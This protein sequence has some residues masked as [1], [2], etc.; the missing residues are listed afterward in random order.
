MKK[1]YSTFC[2]ALLTTFAIAQTDT[3]AP[4]KP[5]KHSGLYSLG[6]TQT[7]LSNWAAG[8]SNSSNFAVLLKQAATLNKGNNT[9]FNLLEVNFGYSIQPNQDVKTDDKIEFTTRYD[10]E[11]G[12]PKWSVSAFGNVRTQL[13]D[14]FANP[15]DS[16]FPDSLRISSFLSPAYATYGL[17][18]TNK[19]IDGLVVYISPATV[20]N[21]FVNDSA[22]AYG[23]SF[24]DINAANVSD[25]AKGKMRWEFGA[26]VDIIYAK[27]F[28]ENLEVSSKLSL[29]SNY[30][31]RPQNIDVTWEGLLLIKANKWLTA[32]L[33]L[34]LIYDH[35]ISVRDTNGDGVL[36]APG[37]Q[38]KEV[39][40]VGLSYSFG[41]FKE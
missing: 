24:F 25:L 16:K 33:L 28:N 22:L 40:G 26:F 18:F 38:F 1:I 23:S 37:T 11:L 14:G 13:L 36:N 15:E 10:R 7:A 29:F 27:Q 32:S 4:E 9:W 8:G 35:D 20:K 39:L 19:S 34:N 31:D 17:G 2:L 3:S 5:W 12:N 41:A 30:L 21:T 6:L